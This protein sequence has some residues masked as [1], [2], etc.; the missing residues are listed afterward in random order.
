MA[1]S[2]CHFSGLPTLFL[3]LK[4]VLIHKT[5]LFQMKQILKYQAYGSRFDLSVNSGRVTLQGTFALLLRDLFSKYSL[6]ISWVTWTSC[7][8]PVWICFRGKW[9]GIGRQAGITDIIDS[10]M[11][12]KEG[13]KW[14]STPESILPLQSGLLGL[15]C[16]GVSPV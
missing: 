14:Q 12:I 16:P 6:D 10:L 9:M 5:I 8:L 11:G 4:S 13:P 3:I 2:S 15:A 7:F 1:S